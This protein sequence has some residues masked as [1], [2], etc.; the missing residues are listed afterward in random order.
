MTGVSRTRVGYAGGATE[1]PTY[2]AMGDHTESIRIEFDPETVSYEELL[3]VFWDSHSPTR[4][5]WSRQYMSLILVQ[6]EAQRRKAEA[7]KAA[8][9]KELGKKLYTE[10]RPA[11][12]FWSAEDYHQKYT[13]RRHDGLMNELYRLYPDPQALIDSTAAARLNGLLSGYGNLKTLASE[14]AALDL[15]QNRLLD[16]AK[17]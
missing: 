2:R 10:I 16:L 1:G 13:L 6:D 11:G 9:E 15:P 12:R 3:E 4:K 14:L 7:S 5:P 8:R 17:G